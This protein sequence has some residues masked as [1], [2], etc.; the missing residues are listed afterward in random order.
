M[1]REEGGGGVKE[2]SR[3]TCTESN[4]IRY[5]RTILSIAFM[6]ESQPAT[7]MDLRVDITGVA[8]N[9]TKQ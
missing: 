8:L 2:G 1:L 6:S 4:G 7:V 3:V 9:L 5:T